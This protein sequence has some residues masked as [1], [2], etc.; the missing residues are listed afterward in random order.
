MIFCIN[1]YLKGNTTPYVYKVVVKDDACSTPNT[2]T[3]TWY[4]NVEDTLIKPKSVITIPP[5]PDS[6]IVKPNVPINNSNT[7]GRR[8]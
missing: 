6:S 5:M 3:L 2:D 1:G 7:Q 4:V 8:N